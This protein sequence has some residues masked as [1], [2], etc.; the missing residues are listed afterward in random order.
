MKVSIES[1][2]LFYHT[3]YKQKAPEWMLD[4]VRFI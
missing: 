1:M 2:C 4:S 3:V